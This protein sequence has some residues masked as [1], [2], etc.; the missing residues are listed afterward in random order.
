MPANK[1]DVIV[2]ISGDGLLYEVINGLASRADW[3]DV[4]R[5]TSIATIPSGTGNGLARSLGLTDPLLAAVNAL[6]GCSRQVDAMAVRFRD[7]VRYGILLAAWAFFSDCDF[8]S[9][10][11]R[12]LGSAR[13]SV[14]AAALV[15]KRRR[16]RA[17]LMYTADSLRIA[18]SVRVS[19]GEP[20]VEPLGPDFDV[21]RLKS[22]G[23]TEVP[24]QFSFLTAVNFGWVSNDTCVGPRADPTDGRIDLLYVKDQV[25][26][27]Q[28]TRM[29][30]RLSKG[31]QLGLSYVNYQ[32]VSA[33]YVDPNEPSCAID[34]DGE[35]GGRGEPFLVEVLPSFVYI[36]CPPAALK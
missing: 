33:F 36:L 27:R 25:S 19:R 10:S 17:R 31:T 4:L 21:A 7:R 32:Q 2:C 14:A 35:V 6:H 20:P 1:Y 18:P 5:T 26:A 12:W 29:L 9:E 16:Y 3:I 13:F 34:L 15:F 8:Q 24:G 11:Y 30:L 28:L 23:W 22:A